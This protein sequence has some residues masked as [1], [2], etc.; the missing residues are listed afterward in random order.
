[1]SHIL[2]Y[3]LFAFALVTACGHPKLNDS[4]DNKPIKPE[5]ELIQNENTFTKTKKT[6]PPQAIEKINNNEPTPTETDTPPNNEPQHKYKGYWDYKPEGPEWTRILAE[7]I[8]ETNNNYSKAKNFVNKEPDDINNYAQNFN[9]MSTEER[10]QVYVSILS[11][12][13]KKESNHNPSQKYKEKFKDSSVRS[14]SE[15]CPVGEAWHPSG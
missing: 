4:T 8:K 12:L 13:S 7:K 6:T 14:H 10:I 11:C 1:M 2:T 15:K 5:N 9:K 3:T